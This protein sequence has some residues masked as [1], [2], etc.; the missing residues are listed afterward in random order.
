M[1]DH[2]R[3]SRVRAVRGTGLRRCAPDRSFADVA[4]DSGGAGLRAG[5]IGHVT[6]CLAL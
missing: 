1:P 4:S 3:D 5:E 6:R 2:P